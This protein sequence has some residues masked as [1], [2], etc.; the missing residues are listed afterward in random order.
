MRT[1]TSLSGSTLK[2]SLLTLLSIIK[3]LITYTLEKDPFK[4]Y[5]LF[6]LPVLTFLS[7]RN[8]TLTRKLT[9]QVSLAIESI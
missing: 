2:H 8:I 5:T 9:N 3:Y 6:T 1:N 4:I 7:V